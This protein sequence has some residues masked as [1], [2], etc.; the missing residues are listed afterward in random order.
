MDILPLFLDR[1]EGLSLFVKMRLLQNAFSFEDLQKLKTR[2]CP[3]VFGR[4]FP[5][6]EERKNTAFLRAQKDLACLSQGRFKACGLWESEYP[7]L[8][9][10]IWDPPFILW[11]QGRSPPRDLELCSVVGTRQPTEKGRY[12]AYDFAQAAAKA[13]LGVVSGLAYGIDGAA[14]SG[15]LNAGGYT[16]AVLAAG[17]DLVIPRG[18]CSLASGILKSGGTLLS[19]FPPGIEPRKYM[20]PRRNRIISGLSRTLLVV[21]APESSGALISATFSLEE[22]R[23]VLV[24]GACLQGPRSAGLRKLWQEGAQVL[25]SLEDLWK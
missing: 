19:E 3:E 5:N 10:C 8:L 6:W 18:H 9:G 15:A 14:H 2:D 12:A 13:G 22:G 17:V 4:S 21:E 1:L 24:H 20:F 7:F 25:E 11:F 16:L 23:D